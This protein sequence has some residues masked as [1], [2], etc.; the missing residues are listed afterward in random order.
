MERAMLISHRKRFIYIKTMKTA[1]TSVESYF[2]PY[3]MAEGEWEFRHG[4]HEYVGP[5]GIIGYRG[6]R[7][8]TH[9]WYNHMPAA[10]IR[11]KAGDSVWNAYYKFCVIRNPF[12]KLVSAFYFFDKRNETRSDGAGWKE[13]LKQ[14]YRAPAAS[15][16][17]EHRIQRFRD[18]LKRRRAP[19]DRDMYTIAGRLCVDYFIRFEDLA[20]GIRDVCARV[21]IPFAP[22]KI[23]KLKSGIRSHDIPLRDYYD[24]DSLVIV[25]K[26]YGFELE[27]F[28]YHE[29]GSQDTEPQTSEDRPQGGVSP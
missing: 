22:E 20:G 1:G 19:M 25:K 7:G 9:E 13:K 18:W 29:P 23:P 14:L 21:D 2:E 16:S 4:R 27:T 17:R 6:V 24:A 10:E 28:G 15:D 8:R 3:C 26:L 11:D 5:E 12:D